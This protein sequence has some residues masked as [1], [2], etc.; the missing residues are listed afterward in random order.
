MS[1]FRAQKY[2]ER[3][4]E[5]YFAEG[6]APSKKVR[7]LE[8]QLLP[9][10]FRGNIECFERENL[11]LVFNSNF[12]KRLHF[13]I[14]VKD[15]FLSK[16]HGLVVVSSKSFERREILDEENSLDERNT[17]R[18]VLEA[19]EEIICELQVELPQTV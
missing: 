12:N 5:D 13:E 10:T 7:L 3:L 9:I 16:H 4:A 18:A 11:E 6:P 8:N 15:T 1:F 14:K 19:K 17:T 2:E